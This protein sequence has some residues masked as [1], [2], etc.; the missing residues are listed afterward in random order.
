MSPSLVGQQMGT[1]PGTI[2]QWVKA[3][4]Y[5]L[6]TSYKVKLS[7]QPKKPE[8]MPPPHQP[9]PQQQLPQQQPVYV[10]QQQQQHHQHPRPMAPPSAQQSP[11]RFQAR[12]AGPPGPPGS[13]V[14]LGQVGVIPR[15]VSV[16][17][18]QQQKVVTAD[19]DTIN[20]PGPSPANAQSSQSAVAQRQKKQSAG[21]PYKPKLF[22]GFLVLCRNCGAT[23]NDFSRCER[24]RKPIPEDSKRIP[25]KNA[26]VRDQHFSHLLH[27]MYE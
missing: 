26:R 14:A 3:A 9:P 24:C 6:P 23:G 4:G 1:S 25:D 13:S 20:D 12:P 18:P 22:P 21:E 19:V 16:Q 2:R 7:Q 17:H 8:A 10:T 27:A 15:A 5:P 11:Q